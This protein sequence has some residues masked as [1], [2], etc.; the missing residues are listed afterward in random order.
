MTVHYLTGILDVY[1]PL[2]RHLFNISAM[3]FNCAIRVAV[4]C[5]LCGGEIC[6][7]DCVWRSMIRLLGGW[8]GVLLC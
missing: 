4:G 1:S 3:N 6:S 5:T 2:N 8:A 7:L